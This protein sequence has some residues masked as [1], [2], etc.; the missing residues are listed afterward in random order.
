MGEIVDFERYRKQRRRRTWDSAGAGRARARDRAG[1][2]DKR[3][4][5]AGE[6]IETGGSVPDRAAKVERDDQKSDQTSD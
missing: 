6:S 1:P 4:E 3:R 2:K 5:Q